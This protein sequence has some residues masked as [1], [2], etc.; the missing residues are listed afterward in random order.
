MT[1]C[2]VAGLLVLCVCGGMPR[3]VRVTEKLVPLMTGVFLLACFA[4]LCLRAERIPSAVMQMLRE[5]FSWRA[6]SGGTAGVWIAMQVGISRGVFTNEAGLGSGTFA[7]CRTAGKTPEQ[8]GSIGALQVFIDTIV[9]CT[10]TALC[11]LVSPGC[12]D[13]ADYTLSSFAAVLGK[14]GSAAVS[15]SMVLFAFATVVAWSCY[16]MDALHFLVPSAGRSGRRI[17]IFFAALACFLGCTLSFNGIISF[18]DMFNGIMA[19]PNIL[20]L[21]RLSQHVFERNGRN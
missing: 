21:L 1:G 8:I 9:L 16:G 19:I 11:L 14:A 13:G 18:C 2:L 6:A 12:G 15:V 7:L 17:Y 3:A 20:A 4:V 5:A 10:V